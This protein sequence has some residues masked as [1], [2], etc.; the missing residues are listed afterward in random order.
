M[1]IEELALLIQTIVYIT[2]FLKFLSIASN[3]RGIRKALDKIV[4]LMKGKN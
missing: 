1:T 4:E 2:L 3:I